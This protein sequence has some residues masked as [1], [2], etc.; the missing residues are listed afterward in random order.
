MKVYLAGEGEHELG[1]WAQSVEYRE[2][3]TR[4]DGVLFALFRR[5]GREGSVLAG[6]RW[7]DI[8]KY[9][10]GG[11]ATAEQR[12]LHQLAIDAAEQGADVLLWARDT[13]GD[14][15][16]AKQLRDKHAELKASFDA[17]LEIIG[18]PANP[19][20]EA[21]IVALAGHHPT[22]ESLSVQ[23]LE[24]L[25]KTHQLDTEQ[26]MVDLINSSELETS[27]SRSLADF[28][29]QLRVAAE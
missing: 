27:R 21:W 23:K 29:A 8:R 7:R 25:T 28:V 10:A 4:S 24:A 12:A 26:A 19:C 16:R 22:P 2:A 5:A 1:R 20:I 15:D 9:R 3:S 11:H 18:E 13:D 14:A 6:K 17:E